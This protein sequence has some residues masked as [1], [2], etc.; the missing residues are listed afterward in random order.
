[1]AREIVTL[2]AN[3]PVGLVTRK[4]TAEKKD[5]RK[6]YSETNLWPEI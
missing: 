4:A 1:M 5:G 6:M 3:M 2:A